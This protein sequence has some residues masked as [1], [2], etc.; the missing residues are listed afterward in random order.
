MT[1]EDLG[2]VSYYPSDGIWRY[3]KGD[4]VEEL[5]EEEA[6]EIMNSYV[7][8]ELPEMKSVKDYPMN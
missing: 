6:F 4:E 5:T 8:V 3:Q 1:R 7:H 2:Q